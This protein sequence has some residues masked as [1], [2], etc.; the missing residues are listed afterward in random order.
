MDCVIITGINRDSD[1][2]NSGRKIGRMVG[3]QKN[4]VILMKSRDGSGDAI[5]HIWIEPRTAIVREGKG[6][7]RKSANINAVI[8]GTE[9]LFGLQ[10]VKDVTIRLGAVADQNARD[11]LR[12]EGNAFGGGSVGFDSGSDEERMS[13]QKSGLC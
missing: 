12:A 2:F 1:E 6:G 11:G 13:L 5:G 9:D 4:F 10:V 7:A 3:G 8:T